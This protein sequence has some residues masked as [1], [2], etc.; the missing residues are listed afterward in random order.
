MSMR[1]QPIGSKK[2]CELMISGKYR[3]TRAQR[4]QSEFLAQLGAELRLRKL[5]KSCN[6]REKQELLIKSYNFLMGD[7]GE[8]FLAMSIF[9]KTLGRILENRGGPAG[10]SMDEK[11]ENELESSESKR[12]KR[13]F[14]IQD[15]VI[16]LISDAALPSPIVSYCCSNEACLECYAVLTI[17][18]EYGALCNLTVE[19]CT[20]LR[21]YLGSESSSIE[22]RL[23]FI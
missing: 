5:L 18:A 15:T 22:V 17:L 6:D 13:E 8:R 16:D 20:A 12:R 2:C 10:F 4:R 1:C 23:P 9:P 3:K 14:D 11:E 21:S 7:M 19:Q